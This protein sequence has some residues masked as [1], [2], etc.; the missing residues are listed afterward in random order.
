VV[1]HLLAWQ[2][3]FESGISKEIL[4]GNPLFILTTERTSGS[5]SVGD[6]N[7]KTIYVLNSVAA[8]VIAY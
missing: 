8:K 7:Y 5:F 3:F 1:L 4:N 6:Y 2:I